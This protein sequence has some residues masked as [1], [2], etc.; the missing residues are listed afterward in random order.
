MI[1]SIFLFQSYY[2]K[3][4]MYGYLLMQGNEPVCF[5]LSPEWQK[6]T[7]QA[8]QM[9][10]W[11]I[12]SIHLL[13][14]YADWWWST[15]SH[16]IGYRCTDVQHC[17][18]TITGVLP[19][20]SCIGTFHLIEGHL[21]GS[22]VVNRVNNFTF[23]C[24]VIPEDLLLS[25]HSFLLILRTFIETHANSNLIYSTYFLSLIGNAWPSLEHG[26]Q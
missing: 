26:Q 19:Y 22:S 11:T 1:D 6:A 10:R 24:L 20:I 12:N 3:L 2:N 21:S 18:W 15:T 14:W 9:H 8:A 13:H 7:D 25:S 4:K 5:G 16:P 23:S 17:K